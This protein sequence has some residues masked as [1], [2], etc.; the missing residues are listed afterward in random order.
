M[1][2]KERILGNIK[3]QLR[4]YRYMLSG[5][6][7]ILKEF[8]QRQDIPETDVDGLDRTLGVIVDDTNELLKAIGRY[9]RA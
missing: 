2:D 9:Q 1:K 8:E 4:V 5:A 6:D 7:I 3:A